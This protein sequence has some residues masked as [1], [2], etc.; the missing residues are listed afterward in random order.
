MSALGLALALGV[1]SSPPARYEPNAGLFL[2]LGGVPIVQ[3]SSFQYFDAQTKK[4]LYSS[5]WN[6]I[7]VIRLPDG[8]TR[9]RYQGLDGLVVGMHEVRPGPGQVTVRYEFRW[10]GEGRVTV[11]NCLG[12]LWA[13]ALAEGTL[14]TDG[15]QF[16]SL[17]APLIGDRAS[18]IFGQAGTRLVFDAPIGKLT[19][20]TDTPTDVFDGRGYSQDWARGRGAFWVG[21]AALTLEPHVTKAVTATWTFE[22]R[23]GQAV[24]ARAFAAESVALPAV[25]PSTKTWPLVPK[26]KRWEPASGETALPL[27]V[28]AVGSVEGPLGN[29]D[30]L[31]AAEDRSAGRLE[32][33]TRVGALGLAPEGYRATVGPEVVEVVGQDLA[34]V[35]HGLASL[36]QLAKRSG[37]RLVLPHGTLTD[38]PSVSWRGVHMFVGPTAREFQG[39][40]MRRVL[41]PLKFDHA[42]LQCERTEWAATPGTRT[43]I[44][45]SKADLGALFADYR[46]NSIEPIPLIQSLGHMEWLLAPPAF[47]ALAVNPETPYTLDVRRQAARDLLEAVWREADALLEP[48]TAHFGLDET[49]S[50]GMPGQESLS[51]RLWQQHLPWLGRLAVSMGVAPMLWGDMALAPGEANDAANGLDKATALAR[52]AAIPRGAWIADWHYADD[53]N[54]DAFRSVPLWKSLGFRPVVASWNKPNNVRG[55][56]LAAAKHGAGHLQTTWAGYESSEA[57]MVKAVPQFAAYVLAAEYAWS[58]EDRAPSALG[59]DPVALLRRLY[60]DPPTRLTARPATAWVV[61]RAGTGSTVGGV[62]TRPFE[63]VCLTSRLTMT[64]RR[65]P[66]EATLTGPVTEASEVA[67]AVDCA[68]WLPD[69][70]DV[71]EVNVTA[72]DGR[73]HRFVLDYG[74]HLRSPDDLAQVWLADR[75]SGLSIVRIRL[76]GEWSVA[77]VT[78]RALDADAGLRV[79]A[80]TLS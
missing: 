24:A 45:M 12:L 38:W 36:A 72:T 54:P 71:A 74:S 42:V 49:D 35:R 53:P 29:L 31:W 16:G 33:K 8:V 65:S 6:P 41:G 18:R 34:G 56:A 11:E 47:R 28:V 69:G 44:T 62:P 20:E 48:K 61:G 13:S 51:T 9:V 3:G 59:Y 78:L 55:T 43:A 7:Q 58:G 68:A 27:E 10:R 50:R 22:P 70:A 5:R 46:A 17:A 21:Q 19:L 30:S 15:F 52:R 80:V 75:Q 40:L 67:L 66:A 25:Q 23:A 1:P 73:S 32:V 37:S 64:G 4:G 79:H 76:P 60:F 26:P 2:D 57:G 39:R 77:S 14:Q 63:P